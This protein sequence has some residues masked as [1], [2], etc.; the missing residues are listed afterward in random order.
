MIVYVWYVDNAWVIKNGGSLAWTGTVNTWGST[1][2][3]Q[4]SLARVNLNGKGAVTACIV[5]D[6]RWESDTLLD[7]SYSDNTDLAPSVI[8]L[9]NC[10]EVTFMV[11][12]TN[13]YAYATFLMFVEG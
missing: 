9:E 10:E 3:A 6:K 2:T 11:G 5:G 4:A 7:E 8:R 12:V 1:V 13:M